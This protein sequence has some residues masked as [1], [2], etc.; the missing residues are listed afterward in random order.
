MTETPQQERVNPEPDPHRLNTEHLRD[1][2]A[3]R[4]TTYDRKI[5]GVAGGL[6]RHLNIDPVIVRVVLVV[7]IF[8][9]GAGII[10]YGAAWLL[11]PEDTGGPAKV[12]T[13]DGT[14]NTLLIIAG[15]VAALALVGDSWGGVGFP[16]PLF[17]IALIVFA[18]MM[19]RDNAP[20]QP[21]VVH[22]PAM[23]YAEPV[24]PYQYTGAE[25]G[26]QLVTPT[27][28][29]RPRKSGPILFG[30]TIALIAAGLGVLGLYDSMA[31]NN[32][33]DAAY[34]AL[35]L[36]LTGLMLVVGAFYGR[37]GGLFFLGLLAAVALAG[38]AIGGPRYD[39]ERD[40]REAPLTASAVRDSYFVP[41]GR[42]ELDLSN[43]REVESLDGR[44]IEVTANAGELLVILPPH[45]GARVEADIDFAGAIDLPGDG[46][47]EGFGAH[48]D[49]TIVVPDQIS[50]IDLELDLDFGHIEVRTAP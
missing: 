25:H 17:V 48:A 28:E 3:L 10:L 38:A 35:A 32:V 22:P 29:R 44:E 23:P 39:G 46:D 12:H 1:Y 49:E 36:A 42:I 18:V 11:V 37:P 24:A 50:T 8:F 34:P 30:F 41:A 9:G 13:S 27:P 47:D 19:S 40:V 31:D 21:P 33:A 7:L 4:R 20:T 15:I 14:R 43:I 45:V 5:A 26:W 16:W 6:A 2:T